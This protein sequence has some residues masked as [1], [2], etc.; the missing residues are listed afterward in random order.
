MTREEAAA[1]AADLEG[2]VV[3]VC[4]LVA[5]VLVL[6]LRYRGTDD[7][8]KRIAFSITHAVCDDWPWPEP[9]AA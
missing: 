1:V 5:G 4:E 8:A 3:D 6:E 2:A 7:G 9:A